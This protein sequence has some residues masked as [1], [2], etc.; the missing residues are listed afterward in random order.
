MCNKMYENVKS[1]DYTKKFLQS[2]SVP[3]TM[4]VVT[5]TNAVKSL[6]DEVVFSLSGSKCTVSAR[7]LHGFKTCRGCFSVQNPT[8]DAEI[9]G[10]KITLLC[11]KI[12]MTRNFQKL[13]RTG[14]LLS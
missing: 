6:S 12:T 1:L 4:E 11:S 9:T 14:G 8:R 3:A 13:R 5:Q 2:D 10:R 7:I